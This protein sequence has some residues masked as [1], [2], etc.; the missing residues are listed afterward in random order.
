MTTAAMADAAILLICARTLCRLP[1]F[2][3]SRFFLCLKYFR[4]IIYQLRNA[5]QGHF[6]IRLSERSGADTYNVW[7][8]FIGLWP[9]IAAGLT[10]E[11][12]TVWTSSS[13]WNSEAM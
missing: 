8:L 11:R 7:N 10:G 3:S 2:S 1:G 6:R 4:L 13:A 12:H 9:V 5:H